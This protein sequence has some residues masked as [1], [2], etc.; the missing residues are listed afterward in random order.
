M[1]SIPDG[2]ID[3]LHAA[4]QYPL[5]LRD[6]GK[7]MR[8][9]DFRTCYRLGSRHLTGGIETLLALTLCLLIERAITLL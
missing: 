6:E 2:A 5:P 7:T 1:A 8:L 9:L 4:E 3:E